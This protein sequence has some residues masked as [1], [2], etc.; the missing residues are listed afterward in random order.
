MSRRVLTLIGL[1]V[2]LPALLLA[3]V[4]IYLTLRI[5]RA[6]EDES[7][8]YDRYIAAQAGEAFERELLDELRRRIVPAENAARAGADSAGVRAALDG[9]SAGLGGAHFMR[10]GELPGTTGII[11]ESTALLYAPGAGARRGLTFA[12]LLLRGPTGEVLGAGG[13]W[14]DPRR[15]LVSRFENVVLTRLPENP[16][17]YG[18]MVATRRLSVALLG[19]YDEE[20]RRVRQPGR[21]AGGSVEALGGPLEGFAVRVAPAADAPVV[22]VTRFIGLM[23]TFIGLVAMV[24]LVATVAGLRYAT[25]QL[26]LAHLKSSFVSNVTHELKTPIALIR[27]AAETLELQRFRTP[28]EGRSFLGSIVRE[29]RR[30]Q[31]LVDNILDFA[32]LEAGQARLRLEPMD[33]A[34][35]A[36]ETVEDFRPRLEQHGFAL[37]TDLPAGLPEVRGDAAMLQH[38]LLNLL[39]NALKYS[40]ERREVRVA[41]AARDGA[42]TLAVTDRGIG[43]AP[44]DQKQVFEKFVRVETGLVHDVKGAGLGL[45]LVHQIVRAHGGRVELVSNP[46]EGSTFTIVLPRAGGDAPGRPAGSAGR[47]PGP[48]EPGKEEG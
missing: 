24:I 16:G 38:C 26:E 47:G 42:V 12:G 21:A 14:L 17:L 11:V 9:A 40:R 35:L 4:G 8:R 41:A 20:L 32:R 37:E 29:T 2:A 44:A 30:L 5:A 31:Q 18:G 45:S 28:E 33:L 6:V 3:G 10:E 13:W 36:R 23:I 27:L 1:G 43:I 25:R 22:W 39:D 19:P 48:A 46:G 34:R 15:F 7:A